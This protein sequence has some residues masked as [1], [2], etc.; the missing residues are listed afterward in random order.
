MYVIRHTYSQ[1]FFPPGKRSYIYI[2]IFRAS[3]S[4]YIQSQDIGVFWEPF[5]GTI[6]LSPGFIYMYIH[7][8][9]NQIY[10]VLITVVTCGFA[11]FTELP[12]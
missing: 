1:D 10:K 7:V 2:Y 8:H 12:W 3:H 4:N 11:L 9:A 6:V 5:N